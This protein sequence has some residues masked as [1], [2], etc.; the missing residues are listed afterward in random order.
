MAAVT[1]LGAIKVGICALLAAVLVCGC[2]STE[3]GQKLEVGSRGEQPP[4]LR[5]AMLIRLYLSEFL[6]RQCQLESFC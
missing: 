4:Y 2:G 3:R 5:H 6:R 1:M